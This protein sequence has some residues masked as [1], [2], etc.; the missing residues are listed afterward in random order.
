MQPRAADSEAAQAAAPPV[1]APREQ[2]A[3]APVDALRD[4]NVGELAKSAPANAEAARQAEGAAARA[5]VLAAPA[6][7]STAA[8]MAGVARSDLAARAGPWLSDDWTDLRVAD[9]ARGI[10][11]PKDQ[12]GRLAELASR[13][14]RQS[15]GAEP[16]QGAI[17]LRVEFRRAGELTGLIE[18]AGAQVR[19]TRWRGGQ[20]ESFMARPPAAQLQALREEIERLLQR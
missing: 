2:R 6:A 16:L 12:G 8:P 11:V 9:Q 1:E 13:M 14:A 15:Q 7:P 3:E 10:E 17:A 20:S 19:W 18:L 4:R 5:P